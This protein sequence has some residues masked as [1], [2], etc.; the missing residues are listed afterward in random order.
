MRSM[1]LATEIKWHIQQR[2][3]SISEVSVATKIPYGN[4]KRMMRGN[5]NF[6]LDELCALEIELRGDR[7]SFTSE[8]L[9]ETYPLK[10]KKVEQKEDSGLPL[11][12]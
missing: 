3:L 11:R 6:K 1:Y 7:F 4:I 5:Y 9:V 8:M 2:K 10:E 12:F